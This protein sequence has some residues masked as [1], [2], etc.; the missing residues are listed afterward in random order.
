[1][2]K[3]NKEQFERWQKLF[4]EFWKLVKDYRNPEKSDDWWNEL[5]EKTS[6][7]CDKYATDNE[8]AMRGMVVGYLSGLEKE[9]K[10]K[11]GIHK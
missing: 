7:I 1:M 5:I 2:S 6:S 11:N 3:M 4:T 9:W 10:E 8:W